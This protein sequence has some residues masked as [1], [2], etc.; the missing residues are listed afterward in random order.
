M[1]QRS[2]LWRIR[3]K[4]DAVR[5]I[6]PWIFS[7]GYALAAQIEAPI[8]SGDAALL[9]YQAPTEADVQSSLDI[10]GFLIDIGSMASFEHLQHAIILIDENSIMK[11]WT[12]LS[13][14]ALAFDWNIAQECHEL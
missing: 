12:S 6:Q 13:E 14:E 8:V 10:L 4:D 2:S 1:Y 9:A 5:P 11:R 7:S 3:T